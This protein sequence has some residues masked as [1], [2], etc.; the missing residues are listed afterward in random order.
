MFPSAAG[1]RQA[2]ALAGVPLFYLHPSVLPALVSHLARRGGADGERQ[3]SEERLGAPAGGFT[4][5][6]VAKRPA[7]ATCQLPAASPQPIT[8]RLSWAPPLTLPAPSRAWSRAWPWAW[9]RT[10]ATAASSELGVEGAGNGGGTPRR[11]LDHTLSSAAAA[12][13]RGLQ[14]I[15]RPRPLN[16]ISSHLDAPAAAQ[17]RSRAR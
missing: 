13:Q 17:P 3:T 15:P 14:V 8:A 6:E 4:P 7:A 5:P 1:R 11:R 9:S 10:G 2:P 12:K 16:P